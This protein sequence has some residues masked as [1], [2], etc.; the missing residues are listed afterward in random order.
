LRLPT[1]LLVVEQV[2]EIIF[3]FFTLKVPEEEEPAPVALEPLLLPDEL[4]MLPLLELGELPAL[5]LL[6]LGELPMLPLLEPEAEPLLSV[7]VMRT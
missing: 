2:L 7:P 4:P 5:P 1:Y 3:T 6:E